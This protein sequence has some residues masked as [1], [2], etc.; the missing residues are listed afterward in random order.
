MSRSQHRRRTGFNALDAQQGLNT[1]FELQHY[2]INKNNQ[3]LQHTVIARAPDLTR[4]LDLKHSLV[5]PGS[6][7]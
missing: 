2:G 5:V 1:A 4:Y 7:S 3:G 6:N